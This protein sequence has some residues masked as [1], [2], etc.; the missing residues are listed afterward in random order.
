M[1]GGQRIR[2]AGGKTGRGRVSGESRGEEEERRELHV[3]V[4]VDL[5]GLLCG[6]VVGVSWVR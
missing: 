3:G 6:S 2:V 4:E 5:V 1:A